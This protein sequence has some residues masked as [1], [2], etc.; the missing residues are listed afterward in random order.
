M[1]FNIVFLSNSRLNQAWVS[2]AP[3][4]CKCLFH[5]MEANYATQSSDGTIRMDNDLNFLRGVHFLRFWLNCFWWT[6]LASLLFSHAEWDGVDTARGV[7]VTLPSNTSLWAE[8][9]CCALLS[10]DHSSSSWLAIMAKSPLTANKRLLFCFF[11]RGSEK[12]RVWEKKPAE[13]NVFRQ[14]WVGPCQQ[15]GRSGWVRARRYKK[16]DAEAFSQ[17][18]VCNR[19]WRLLGFSARLEVQWSSGQFGLFSFSH[20]KATWKVRNCNMPQ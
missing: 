6:F 13:S 16:A 12:G 7:Y 2:R 18:G 11:W 20:L 17:V 4:K 1:G 3:S 15:A 5:E 14:Q 19:V 10:L 8:A 9:H